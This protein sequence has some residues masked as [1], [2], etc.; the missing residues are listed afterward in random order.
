LE[1]LSLR[2][3]VAT[4]QLHCLINGEIQHSYS[5]ATGAKGLGE[6]QGSEQTPRGWHIVLSKIGKGA[7]LGTVFVGRQPTGE[8]YSPELAKTYPQRDWILTRILWLGGLEIGKNRYGTVD[9]FSR[10]IYI[11]GCPD[12]IPLGMPSSHGC[13]RMHNADIVALFDRVPLGTK[14]YIG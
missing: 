2:V 11:H 13:V 8:I 1:E 4:Q 6:E 3:E 12:E 10:Y 5:I 14:V 7:P 9:T